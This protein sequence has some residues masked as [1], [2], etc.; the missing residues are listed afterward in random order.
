MSIPSNSGSRI[1]CVVLGSIKHKRRG[2]GCCWSSWLA[3]DYGIIHV[4]YLI[5]KEADKR[6]HLKCRLLALIPEGE[7]DDRP[8][9]CRSSTESGLPFQTAQDCRGLST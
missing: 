1:L 9:S 7:A 4:T 3:R 6:R 2:V 5:I 8:D